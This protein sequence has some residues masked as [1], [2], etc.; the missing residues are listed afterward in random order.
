MHIGHSLNKC[1]ASWNVIKNNCALNKRPN[2]LFKIYLSNFNKFCP[3]SVKD[4]KNKILPSDTH[5]LDL[6]MNTSTLGSM[7]KWKTVTTRDVLTAS[8]LILYFI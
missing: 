7:F 5:V 6:V 3:D 1:K 2:T 4:I 8:S